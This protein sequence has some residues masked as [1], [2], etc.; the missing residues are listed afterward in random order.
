MTKLHMRSLARSILKA[1][2]ISRAWQDP[3]RWE[4]DCRPAPRSLPARS[5]SA[6]ATAFRQTLFGAAPR[7]GRAALLL[8][9]GHTLVH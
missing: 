4:A 8:L 9:T 5:R 2:A 3:L 6:H 7:K 1:M